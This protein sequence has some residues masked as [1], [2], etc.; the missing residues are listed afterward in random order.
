MEIRRNDPSKS[1][2]GRAGYQK[3]RKA[4]LDRD[5]H[6]CVICLRGTDDGVKV[7]V[8]HKVRW[9]DGG[10]DSM[11]NMETLCVDHHKMKTKEE[12]SKPQIPTPSRKWY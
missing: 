11:E 9:K 7:E 8:D 3:L 4:V 6:R 5:D 10:E 12:A 1:R 2:T